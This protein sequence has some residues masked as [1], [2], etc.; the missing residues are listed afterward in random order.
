MAQNR[1]APAYQEYPAT[2]LAQINFRKMSL[3]DRGLFCTMRFECWVNMKL[4]ASPEVLAKILGV[5]FQQVHE[6]LP[7]VMPYFKVVDDLLICPE[8]EDYRTHLAERRIKQSE[9]GKLGSAKT[10]RDRKCNSQNGTHNDSSSS[11]VTRRGNH[12]PLDKSKAKNQSQNQSTAGGGIR[13]KFVD[14]YEAAEN[15]SPD[16]YLKASKGR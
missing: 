10:N 6:S 12:E 9:G 5:P 11:Q 13:D 15:C 16:E 4:P 1:E 2:I 8:L 3:Q 14:D 7:A